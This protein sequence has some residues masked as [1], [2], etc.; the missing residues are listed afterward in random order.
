MPRVGADDTK[1]PQENRSFHDGD[2][3][4][5][6]AVEVFKAG[7]QGRAGRSKK[8]VNTTQPD[9]GIKLMPSIAGSCEMLQ[10]EQVPRVGIEPTT[11]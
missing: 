1:I 9:G 11:S 4:N 7:P 3:A 5:N 6:G 8:N 10:N 2:G